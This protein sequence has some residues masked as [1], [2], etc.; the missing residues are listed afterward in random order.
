M[1]FEDR[2]CRL[3]NDLLP[4]I[5]PEKDR[6]SNL[7]RVEVTSGYGT[8]NF[9]FILNNMPSI[10]TGSRVHGQILYSLDKF[11]V[12]FDLIEFGNNRLIIH[13][14][15]LSSNRIERITYFELMSVCISLHPYEYENHPKLNQF[16]IWKENNEDNLKI[17]RR[18]TEFEENNLK[19]VWRNQSLSLPL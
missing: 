5:I 10:K 7:I 8:L 17:I 16:F 13:I 6:T 2:I 3:Y 11:F 4:F 1:R 12:W 15:N 14:H 18:L 9:H 19:K